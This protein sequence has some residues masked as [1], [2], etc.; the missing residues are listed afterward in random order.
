MY[1]LEERL[2]L[3]E[4]LCK[5]SICWMLDAACFRGVKATRGSTPHALLPPPAHL[6]GPS[7]LLSGASHGYELSVAGVY[8]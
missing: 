2:G 1:T 5:R 8:K 4:Q 6:P 3:A 7:P